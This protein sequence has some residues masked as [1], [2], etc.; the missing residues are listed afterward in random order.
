M[1][2]ERRRAQRETPTQLSYIQLDPNT[3]GIIL[4]ASESGLA[5]QV[6]GAVRSGR[7]LQV[8]ISPNPT[9]RIE[10]P[11]EIAWLDDAKTCGGVRFKEPSAEICLQ[12]R[13]WLAT[14]CHSQG[15]RPTV[16]APA[17]ATGVA[18][19]VTTEPRN[20][21]LALEKHLEAERTSVL[22]RADAATPQGTR[23]DA[24]LLRG[25][26]FDPVP[27]PAESVVVSP[28]HLF[29]RIAA[30]I[31]MCA[32]VFTPLLSG[33]LRSQFA[34]SLIRLGEKLKGSERARVLPAESIPAH[35]SIAGSAKASAVPNANMEI[36]S[37]EPQTQP[38]P[39]T[40]E[41]TR[42]KTTTSAALGSEQGSLD[43]RS[44]RRR[45]E[46]VH[47]LWSAIGS[48]DTSAEVSLAQL[49]MTGDGVPK[50]CAQARIL[51]RAAAKTGNAEA[52][53]QLQK[54]KK[55]GCR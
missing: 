41:I 43:A 10:L 30:G 38:G 26:L 55:S 33:N 45:G 19:I 54:L 9:E 27:Q 18:S 28:A 6:V 4:N 47:Q 39:S 51:L 17:D 44:A 34:D 5:F 31:L 1:K 46:L 42:Q 8:C 16:A 25:F 21:N 49:Y 11:G 7:P 52:L 2:I 14:A 37:D 35:S 32:I 22:G 12:I 20:E 3:G 13:R 15:P 53:Q 50:N 29:L 23:S 40:S 36:R 24:P 48:G